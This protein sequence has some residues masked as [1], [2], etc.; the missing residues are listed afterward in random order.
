MKL[1]LN[2]D[3]NGQPGGGGDWRASLPDDLKSA[4]VLANVPDVPT[5]VKNYINA[6]SLIGKKRLPLP[7]KNWNDTQWDDFYKQ[8]GRPETPDKYPVPEFKFEEGL[9]VQPE[10]VDKAKLQFHKL[11]LSEKQAKGILEYY[12]GIENERFKS[13]KESMSQTRAQAEEAMKKEFGDKYESKLA[14]AK[15]AL[16]RFDEPGSDFVKFLDESKLGNDPRMVKFLT[17]VA[18]KLNEDSSGSAGS[19]GLP[20][21]GPERA[22]LE[23]VNLKADKEFMDAFTKGSKPHV[24][25]WNDLH[26]LAYK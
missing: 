2:P 10:L 7:E 22:K 13:G 16:T 11:G 26:N 1:L 18:D 24:Q 3:P 9:A 5:L 20:L 12:F 17:R 25:R 6:E 8:A 15:A 4:S 23:I 19:T 14:L 21:P